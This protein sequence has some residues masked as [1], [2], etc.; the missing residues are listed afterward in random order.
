MTLQGRED[1]DPQYLADMNENIHVEPGAGHRADGWGG[2]MRFFRENR[3][4][5]LSI[6]MLC[7]VGAI[8][9]KRLGARVPYVAFIEGMLLGISVVFNVA[10]LARRPR[11]RD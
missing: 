8:V 3:E 2:E 9:L 10:Y 1:A 5:V 6:G 7:L 4:A 11:S